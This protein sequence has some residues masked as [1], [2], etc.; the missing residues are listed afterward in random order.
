MIPRS[1]REDLIKYLQELRDQIEIHRTSKQRIYED[2]MKIKTKE[3]QSLDNQL[4][5]FEEEA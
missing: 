3:L 4:R 1:K 5:K 2:K